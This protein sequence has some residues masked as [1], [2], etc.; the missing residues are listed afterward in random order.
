MLNF[1]SFSCL[2]TSIKSWYHMPVTPK[3]LIL[4]LK[5]RLQ[6]TSYKQYLNSKLCFLYFSCC[7]VDLSQSPLNRNPEYKISTWES[8][9]LAVPEKIRSLVSLWPCATGNLLSWLAFKRLVNEGSPLTWRGMPGLPF[10]L[11]N[12]SGSA[13]LHL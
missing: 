2:A 9:G 11:L 3:S 4:Q 8:A 1:S 7:T 10:S 5:F 13:T 6:P 12:I